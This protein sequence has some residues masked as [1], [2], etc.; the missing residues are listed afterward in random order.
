MGFFE[1]IQD[2]MNRGTAAAERTGRTVQIRHQLGELSRQR[3]DY[4]TQLGASL[5]E[6]VKADAQLRSGREALLDGIATIDQQYVDLSRELAQIEAEAAAS[7]QAQV[8]LQCT[9]C[10]A[11]VSAADFF[12]SECGTSVADIRKALAAQQSV[13]A[14]GVEVPGM[15]ACSQCGALCGEADMFCMQCGN[16]LSADADTSMEP[17]VEPCVSEDA[18]GSDDAEHVEDSEET[19]VQ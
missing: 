6:T 2:A 11:A 19:P 4:M 3:R 17:P 8:M 16:R 9:T 13:P 15:R 14:S 5:Y 10:G 7:Q 12:C 18:T 1:N